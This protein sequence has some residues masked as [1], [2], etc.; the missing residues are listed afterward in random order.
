MNQKP[1]L[2]AIQGILAISAAQMA[3]A[4]TTKLQKIEVVEQGQQA[5]QQQT[6]DTLQLRQ[7]GNTETGNLL[8]Q[9]NGVS[10]S[11][12]GGHGQEV[13][14]R[15]QQQPQLN[16]LLDGAKIEAGCPNRMDPPT[17]YAEGNSYNQVT[18]IKGVRSLQYGP[19]GSGGTVLF[20]REKPEYDA[21][22]MVSGNASIMKSNVM[23]YDANA[24][25]DVVAKQG[26]LVLQGS[27]KEA[28]NYEDGNGDTVA[29]SYDT[30]QGHIDLGWTPSDNHHLKLSYEQ[31]NTADALFPGARMDSPKSDGTIA[32]LKY[33]G[34]KISKLV[35][36]IN[37]DA[38]KS[39]VDHVMNNFSLRT[40]P[41]MMGSEVKRETE[42][43]TEA[44]GFKLSLTSEI[45]ATQITYGVQAQDV[46]K[47][48]T[49][50][51]RNNDQSLFLMWPDA[52]TTQNSF[53]AETNTKAG[54]GQIIL[55]LRY[56]DVTAE[57]K[58]ATTASDN[59][60]KASGLYANAYEDYD[61][62]SDNKTTE[63]NLSGLARYEHQMT[64]GLNWFTG[65]SHTK[66][67][68]DETERYMAKGGNVMGTMP[69]VQNHWVG[70]PNLK[71]EKHNQLDIGIGQSHATFDWQLSAWY[72]KV[73]DYIL[74]D[75]AVNQYSNGVKTSA[76]GNTQVY[77]NVDAELYGSELSGSWRASKQLQLGGQVAYTSGKNTTDNRYIYT[78]PPVNGNLNAQYNQSNWNLGGR[79]NF[80]MEQPDLDNDYTPAASFGKTPAWSTVDVFAGLTLAKQWNIKAGVDNVLDH[81]YYTG[82]KQGTLGESY[83][84]NEP[85]RNIWAR[86]SANF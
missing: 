59:G 6:E 8:R 55:G 69:P 4:D 20:E 43:D 64:N 49:F 5:P 34:S 68:A 81:A 54:N 45:G 26:Y 10:T 62:D 22:K 60:T 23:N 67:T 77:V 71:P 48:A 84:V 42:A 18:V 33:E 39:E 66:R 17:A 82:I 16:I 86:V 65:I 74:R 47:E 9:I 79:F 40:P 25:M 36:D 7:T 72:D 53:F 21:E 13:T 24:E 63:G 2:F 80:A 35:S 75:L 12:M 30:T 78:I 1:L 31:S 32:R 76:S 19:G 70:N 38:Y 56:D 85:G 61:S 11:R 50:Y 41:S 46:Q 44:T 14:I 73:D 37:I 27:R 51:N 29:S 52:Q 28:N 3:L 58:K 57:A 15:G 83:K